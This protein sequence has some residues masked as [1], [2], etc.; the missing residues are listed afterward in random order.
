M[1]YA[2]YLEG[3]AAKKQNKAENTFCVFYV[4]GNIHARAC[5]L[6][7]ARARADDDRRS[8]ATTGCEH[9]R[10]STCRTCFNDVNN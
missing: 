9:V 5:L 2:K 3:S 7:A 10:M 4:T 1:T 6:Y 8:V